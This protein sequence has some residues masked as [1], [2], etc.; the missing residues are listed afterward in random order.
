M[1]TIASNPHARY[2]HKT[3]CASAPATDG[4]GA[5][6]TNKTGESAS[7]ISFNMLDI[8]LR[9]AR[10]QGDLGQTTSTRRC[11]ACNLIASGKELFDM[12]PH[13][14]WQ[15]V[16][17]RVRFGAAVSALDIS[18]PD[19]SAPGLFGARTFFLDSF[20]CSYVVSVCNSLRSR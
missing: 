10:H 13:C 20:F 5:Y 15:E 18:S 2:G 4:L 11:L 16:T 19:I 9:F 3:L 12:Q 6:S 8:L 14:Q 1:M 17:G 7:P